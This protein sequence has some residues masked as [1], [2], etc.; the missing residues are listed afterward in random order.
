ML[1][2]H[3]SCKNAFESV[4]FIFQIDENGIVDI[5]NVEVVDVEI[6]ENQKK[7]SFHTPIKYQ[8]EYSHHQQPINIQNYQDQNQ[9]LT[10]KDQKII[11]V[12]NARN[13]LESFI[14]HYKEF[15]PLEGRTL[16]EPQ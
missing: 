13:D 6:G 12:Q 2:D 11:T 4:D 14:Y 10:F 16:I 15:V 3:I 9:L 7:K 1:V 5:K 8:V